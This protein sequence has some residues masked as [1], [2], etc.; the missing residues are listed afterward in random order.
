MILWWTAAL[1]LANPTDFEGRTFFVG[2]LHVHTAASGDGFSEDIGAPCP[3]DCGDLEAIG[4]LAREAGLDFLAVTDHVNGFPIS[5][6]VLFSYAHGVA[7]DSETPELVVIPGAEIWYRLPDGTEL[8]HKNLMLFGDRSDFAGFTL[9]D[10]QFNGT[11][12]VVPD[13]AAIWDHMAEVEAL[14][15]PALLIP[16]HPALYVP[17]VTDWSCNDIAW[18]PSVEIYS[19]HGNS[20][21]S[22]TVF[23]PPWSGE[24]SSG[25]VA[26]ALDPATH[27]LHLGFVGGTDRH[28]TRPGA[29]CRRDSVLGGPDYGGG[30]TMFSLPK[31]EPLTRAAIRDAM[32]ARRTYA[33][34]GPHLPAVAELH[35][36]DGALLGEL[37]EVSY[38]APDAPVTLEVRVGAD[39]VALVTEVI[40][41]SPGART[42][43]VQ[44][45]GG[46]WELELAAGAHPAWVYAEI[47]LDGAAWYP[48][49]C[50]DG[51]ETTE[52]HLWLSP[53]WIE[54]APTDVDGDG[55]T[56]SEGDCDDGDPGVYPG[57][58]EDCEDGVDQDC[59]G[60][61]DAEDSECDPEDTGPVETGG[62]TAPPEETD[63]PDTEPEPVDTA[64]TVAPPSEDGCGC[65]SKAAVALWLPGL[66]AL[67]WRRRRAGA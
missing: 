64:G 32:L 8:G 36:A 1:A 27:G 49:G 18:A 17:M 54:D 42:P 21:R 3:G 34:S 30:L 53:I 63:S 52:E 22:K 47:V 60:D 23:D 65:G 37:G 39:G 16:H 43:M 33:T 57:A 38:A 20:D 25:V 50:L 5:D 58:D 29:V 19:E 62:D 40:A 55:Y 10:A 48:E 66:L 13:C 15:G 61:I 46:A 35:G 56:E 44:T 41:V 31:G 4:P 12:D 2:D 26:N 51:G 14:F 45:K 7:L 67:G 24:V 59:D 28:D 6:A 9:A 11:G